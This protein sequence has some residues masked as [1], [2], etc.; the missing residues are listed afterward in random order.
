MSASVSTEGRSWILLSTLGIPRPKLD[1][2]RTK[3]R[4]DTL[5]KKQ[6]CW[7]DKEVTSGETDI[8]GV[9]PEVSRIDRVVISF[10]KSCLTSWWQ[11]A[12]VFENLTYWTCCS[13][14]RFRE[15]LSRRHFLQVL[16]EPMTYT[17][18]IWKAFLCHS[19]LYEGV[20]GVNMGFKGNVDRN[21]S[22]DGSQEVEINFT[23]VV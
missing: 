18:S 14:C 4:Q 8:F 6:S 15:R 5:V 19:S 23:T 2:K 9:V 10:G 3:D 13:L 16:R 11:S 17:K 22:M 12:S 20:H 21:L 1:R 7:E